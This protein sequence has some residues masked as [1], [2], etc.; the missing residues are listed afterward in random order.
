MLRRAAILLSLTRL[1]HSDIQRDSATSMAPHPLPEAQGA[2]LCE[3]TLPHRASSV[4]QHDYAGNPK[5]TSRLVARFLARCAELAPLS[6]VPTT[7]H[8]Q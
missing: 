1:H 5:T 6:D 8:S 4:H 2:R 7:F 3:K